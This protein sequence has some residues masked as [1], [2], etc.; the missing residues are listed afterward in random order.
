MDLMLPKKKII[1]L[2]FSTLSL[3][4]IKCLISKFNIKNF[5]IFSL[6]QDGNDEKSEEI[7]LKLSNILEIPKNKIIT[8]NKNLI[9]CL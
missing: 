4:S 3:I 9:T 2:S 1:F 7:S 6:S 5:I 8:L